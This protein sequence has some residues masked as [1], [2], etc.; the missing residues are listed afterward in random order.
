MK[1]TNKGRFLLPFFIGTAIMIAGC[2]KTNDNGTLT[3]SAKSAVSYDAEDTYSEWEEQDATNITFDDQSIDV[4]DDN[5]GVIVNENT[6]EI[7]TSGT[8][9]LEGSATDSQVLVDAEDEGT[10]RLILNGLS[11]ESTSTAPIF[12]KQADKTVISVEEG[13]SNTLTDPSEYVYEEDTDEPKAA[14]YSKDDLTINGTG[15]LNVN[16][17]YNDGI[18]GNDDLKIIGTTIDITA[19]DDGIVGRDLFAMNEALITID[20]GGDGV[21]SSNDTDED[22]ANVVLESGSLIINAGGDGVQSENTVTILDGEYE[23]TAGGGSPETIEATTEFGGGFGGQ[24]QGAMPGGQDFSEDNMPAERPDGAEGMEP[25]TEGDGGEFEDRQPP[26]QMEE[27]QA[28]TNAETEEDDTPSTKGIKAENSLEIAGGT[29]AIDAN[30]DALHS[31]KE[32]TVAA[33]EMTLATGDDAV[34]ADE[35]IIITNGSIQ[36]DKS[37]EGIEAESITVSDGTIHL[38]AEDDGFNVN[39]GTDQMGMQGFWENQTENEEESTEEEADQGKLLI[40]GGYIYV[41]ANGDGLDSNTS[42]EMT[43]GTVLVYGPTNNGNGALDYDQSFEIKGGTLI[44]AG[45]SGM[46]QG[47]S[48]SSEQASFMMTFPEMLEAGTTVSVQDGNGD[49]VVAVAPEK[50]FQSVVISSPDLKQDQSYTLYTDNGLSGDETDGFFE[51]A[52][53]EGGTK[54]LEFSLTSTM[55][56]LDESGETEQPSGM[57]GG[58]R[59]QGRQGQDDNEMPQPPSQ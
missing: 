5:N 3:E 1:K 29:I 43:G 8:Y 44:A 52:T 28:Q 27:E 35:E 33:G 56:Y 32:L 22:K 19:E 7:H 51:D 57:F 41:D 55:T 31:N 15:N 40:E 12:V 17:N 21:K 37:Y 18:T 42:A 53:M 49:I 30:D 6:V 45:S 13:T 14:I 47:V 39:G 10:V 26:E 59:G 38:A 50:D 2:S 54:V 46:A 16:S 4:E 34:H 20:A 58:G 23:I 48:D 36:V 24:R 9:V 11:L 25:P